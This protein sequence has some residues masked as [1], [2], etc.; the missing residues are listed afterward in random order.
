[1]TMTM[2]RLRSIHAIQ[3]R[4]VFTLL[5]LLSWRNVE[6]S[7]AYVTTK[8]ITTQKHQRSSHTTT[9][10]PTTT[11]TSTTTTVNLFSN[12]LETQNAIQ[13]RNNDNE[14]DASKTKKRRKPCLCPPED[15]T[16]IEEEEDDDDVIESRR[17]LLFAMMGT[18][19]AVT[20]TT[21]TITAFP[22]AA[23]ATAGVDAKMA[24]PDVIQGMNDRN[25]KQCLVESLGNRECLVYR[26]DDPDKL[27]YKGA[28]TQI[29]LQRIQ[30]TV[31]ALQNIP[32]LVETKQWSKITGL[33]TGPMGQLSA[34][35]TLL[36]KGAS[37]PTAAQIKANAL[38]QDV[39][40][41]GTATTQRQTA[42]ILKYQRRAIQ[43]LEV[44]LQ[45][46]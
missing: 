34:T 1:M 39:F 29:L 6:T 16:I 30:T 44:F 24:F 19:W 12:A 2:K 37:N 43:D 31:D 45:S 22:F 41:I 36:V 42:D 3:Y 7:H 14:N 40:A 5:L 8:T 10:N 11:T 17:E 28:D 27:L 35:L 46:L 20:T 18:V 33:L 25:T 15:D 13:N 32:P 4:L 38:K 21:T 26:Q 9:T 23:H